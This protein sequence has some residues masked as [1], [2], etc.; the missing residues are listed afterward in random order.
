LASGLLSR[1][2]SFNVKNTGSHSAIKISLNPQAKDIH[3][4]IGLANSLIK[5]ISLVNGRGDIY[6]SPSYFVQLSKDMSKN[7]GMNIKTLIGKELKE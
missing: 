3:K 7:L 2:Y 4:V 6:G 1:A 5:S